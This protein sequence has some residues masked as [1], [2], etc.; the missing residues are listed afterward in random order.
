MTKAELI[1]AISEKTDYTKSVVTEIVNAF[2]EAVIDGLQRGETVNLEQLGKLVP[3]EKAPRS[4]RNPQN[5]ELIQIQGFRTA[6]LRVGKTLKDAL[7]Q[8]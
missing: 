4:G 2:N 6:K 1:A 5:G 8:R 3:V 7:N